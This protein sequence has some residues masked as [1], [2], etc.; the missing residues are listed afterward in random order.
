M[1]LNREIIVRL[2]NR[3][4]NGDIYIYNDRTVEYIDSRNNKELSFSY[5][6]TISSKLFRKLT[7]LYVNYSILYDLHYYLYDSEYFHT[8]LFAR[9]YKSNDRF[10]TGSYGDEY[11]LSG[12]DNLLFIL[13][14]NRLMNG[15]DLRKMEMI[16]QIIFDYTIITT[17][18]NERIATSRDYWYYNSKLDHIDDELKKYLDSDKCKIMKHGKKIRGI[19][20]DIID[21]IL[22]DDTLCKWLSSKITVF[23]KEKIKEVLYNKDTFLPYALNNMILEYI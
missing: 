11:W 13:T 9:Y 14:A 3:Y 10:A 5:D 18:I 21:S 22:I 8:P 6:S 16:G 19:R 15:K 4:G 20:Y 12:N 17:N 1:S 7:H 23:A 2:P